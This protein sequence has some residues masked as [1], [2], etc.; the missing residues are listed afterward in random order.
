VAVRALRGAT[1]LQADDATEMNEAVAELLEELLRRNDLTADD[2]I[3]VLFT[4]TPD[5]HV[6]FPALGARRVGFGEVPLLCAQ[7][8]AVEGALPRVVRVLA[9]TETARTRSEMR[10]V[11]L[12]GTEVLRRDL[13]Q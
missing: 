10:H 9:H 2:V 1:Q 4:A 11:Y 13:A 6:Q 3:S 8:I 7:E 5:L 12:R